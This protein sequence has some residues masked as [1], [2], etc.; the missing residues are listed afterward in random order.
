MS[1]IL[2]PGSSDSTFAIY[3]HVAEPSV[4]CRV[5]KKR[6]KIDSVGKARWRK[7]RGRKEM[8]L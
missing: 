4:S 8:E 3:V 1:S 6:D 2:G 7:R 5:H